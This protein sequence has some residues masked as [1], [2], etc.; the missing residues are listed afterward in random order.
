MY[1]EKKSQKGEQIDK[2]LEEE[3]TAKSRVD[4][5]YL[6]IVMYF[7]CTAWSSWGFSSVILRALCHLHSKWCEKVFNSKWQSYSTVSKL[8]TQQEGIAGKNNIFFHTS[9]KF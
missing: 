3:I 9:K 5:R 6:L 8:W 4:N 1:F 7:Q 2:D